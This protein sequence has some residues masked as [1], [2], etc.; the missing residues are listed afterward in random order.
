M[1]LF[2]LMLTI[3]FPPD[4]NPSPG[5]LAFEYVVVA[6][7]PLY[8]VG[9][10]TGAV[11]IVRAWGQRRQRAYALRQHHRQRPNRSS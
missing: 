10:V 2:L 6:L 4:T 8:V 7:T 9:V 5:T 1:A 11:A 3:F